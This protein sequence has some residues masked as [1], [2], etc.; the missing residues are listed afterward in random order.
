MIVTVWPPLVRDGTVR[1]GW[2]QEA[3]NQLQHR[4]RWSIG[5]PRIPLCRAAPELLI[6]VLLSLQLPVWAAMAEEV[7]VRLPFPIPG[8]VARWWLA[9]HD[10]GHV[11]IGPLTDRT[12]YR[13]WT[14]AA[15]DLPAPRPVGVTFG[16]GKDSTLAYEALAE[17][18]GR[19]QVLLFHAIHPFSTRERAKRR[20]AKRSRTLLLAPALSRGAEVQLLVTDFMANLVPGKP[21]RPGVNLYVTA[22]LPALLHRGCEVVTVS[23]TAAGYWVRDAPGGL[24]QW[25]NR[26]N[27]PEALA[28]LGHYYSRVLGHDLRPCTT[29]YPISEYVSFKTLLRRYPEAFEG[30]VMCMRADTN[31]ARWCYD[32]KKCFEYAVFGLSLGRADPTFD[33]D[34]LFGRSSYVRSLV[35]HVEG[36]RPDALGRA[37]WA[38][39]VGTRTHFAA[40]CHALYL[41]D[42]ALLDGRL[43]A[44]ATRHLAVLR[45]GFGAT[46]FPAV[47]VIHRAAV[48][49][50]GPSPAR[51]VARVAAGYTD[52]VDEPPGAL[53]LGNRVASYA[54]GE[55]APFADVDDVLAASVS[56][57]GHDL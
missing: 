33:F 12:S 52:V 9:Y 7:E 22:G 39:V 53:L 37:R 50:C 42:S 54:H 2:D 19:D 31:K 10:I 13:P 47:D 49:A 1:F 29:H 23:Y 16:A 51:A 24:R 26:R 11:T 8:V 6:E 21:A 18:Y 35:T 46:P 4:N 38:A 3:T 41:T 14:A 28:A 56:A 48:D 44:T 20:A 5:Y 15:V 30:I 27:R 25:G 34:A 17:T 40:L 57:A 43:G 36:S 45:A 55:R 32:C